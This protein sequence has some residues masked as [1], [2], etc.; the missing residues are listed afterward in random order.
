MKDIKPLSSKKPPAPE[1]DHALVEAWIAK[2]MPGL[3][4]ILK[5][6]DKQVCKELKQPVYAIKWGK[7]YFGS[8]K[9]GWCI[10]LV[11]YDISVNIVFLNGS[12]LSEP[13]EL[14]SET[15]YVKVRSLEE[16]EAT[17]VQDWIKQSCN[18][19]GWKAA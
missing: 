3:Q 2:A 10:E 14:G 12:R 6:I 7:A 5:A 8:E 15:R 1:I 19:P 4:G 9:L 13:P 11:A 16:T 18:L 17:E